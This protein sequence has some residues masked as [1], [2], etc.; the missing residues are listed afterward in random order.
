M[1][2]IFWVNGNGR[3][4]CFGLKSLLFPSFVFLLVFLGVPDVRLFELF[5]E[6]LNDR[7]VERGLR[8]SVEKLNE[9]F[10]HFACDLVSHLLVAESPLVTKKCGE[11]CEIDTLYFHRKRKQ[12]EPLTSGIPLPSVI[13]SSVKL[14]YQVLRKVMWDVSVELCDKG[15]NYFLLCKPFLEFFFEIV[16]GLARFSHSVPRV[17]VRSLFYDIESVP[18][19]RDQTSLLCSLRTFKVLFNNILFNNE[20]KNK[21]KR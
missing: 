11:H 9:R 21:D 13:G 6:T 10:P 16:F 17:R 4:L 19:V 8:T 3:F 1:L 18:S 12:Y 7:I 15:T 20:D 5:V 14:P 2:N